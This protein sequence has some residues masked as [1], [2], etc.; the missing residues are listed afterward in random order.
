MG[1]ILEER[2]KGFDAELIEFR[3]VLYLAELCCLQIN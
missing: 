1:E 3:R 2:R